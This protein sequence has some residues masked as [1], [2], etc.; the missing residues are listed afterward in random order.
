REDEG[1]GGSA[2]VHEQFRLGLLLRCSPP[3]NDFALP[4]GGPV[5]LIA[6][7]IGITPIKAMAHTLV[8]EQRDFVLHYAVRSR[9]QALFVDQLERELGPRLVLHAADEGRRLSLDKVMDGAAVTIACGPARM[10]DAV[11]ETGKR[12]GVRVLIERFAAG[13]AGAVNKPVIVTLK[14][15]RKVIEVPASASI[16]AAVEAAGI[17]APASCRIGNCG[18]C[19]VKVLGGTP[20]HRDNALSDVERAEKMCICVSRASGDTLELDL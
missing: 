14:R 5:V 20:E 17:D 4:A 9:R 1:G 12:L 15:S 8:A 11:T 3:R 18:T 6:G 16:L 10:L 7:G 13:S 19:A 2:G